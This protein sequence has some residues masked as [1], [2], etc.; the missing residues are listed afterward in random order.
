[1]EPRTPWKLTRMM[2]AY[3]NRSGGRECPAHRGEAA[4]SVAPG[5]RGTLRWVRC[6]RVRPF[7][8]ALALLFIPFALACHSECTKQSDCNTDG[9]EMCLWPAGVGCGKT[10]GHC[11]KQDRCQN[12]GAPINLCSCSGVTLAPGCIPGNGITEQTTNGI[13]VAE[14]GSDAGAESDSREQ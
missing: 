9:G 13:C 12:T 11:E 5:L 1:M 14:A 2:R 10:E 7:L 3:Q 6:G 8:I 4:G